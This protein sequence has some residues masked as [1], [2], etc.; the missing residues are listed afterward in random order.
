[1]A[2]HVYSTHWDISIFLYSTH[3]HVNKEKIHLY[4]AL[5]AL[6]LSCT[7]FNVYSATLSFTYQVLEWMLFQIMSSHTYTMLINMSTMYTCWPWLGFT[8]AEICRR[9]HIWLCLLVR[10]SWPT[11]LVAEISIYVS[12][13]YLRILKLHGILHCQ[14]TPYIIRL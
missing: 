14:A 4:M 2:L 1:M 9:G 13:F 7:N 3:W 11:L 8:F 10:W 5:H 12:L 6:W